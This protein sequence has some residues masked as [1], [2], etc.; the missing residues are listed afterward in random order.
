[1]TQAAILIT[2]TDF[3]GKPYQV[4]LLVLAFGTV[5]TIANTLL[6]KYLAP[7]EI[8]IA[9]F[10]VLGYVANIIVFWVMAP[11]NSAMEVFGT[12]TN[13]N[14]WSSFGFG[15]LTAQTAALYLIIG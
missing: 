12:F 14:G 1:M 11:K 7:M 4:W 15:M 13:R 10:F 2:D 6:A 5:A 8:M 9:A 3:N